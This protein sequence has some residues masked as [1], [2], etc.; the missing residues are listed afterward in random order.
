MEIILENIRQ[1]KGIKGIAIGGKELKTSAFDDYVT[2]YIGSNSSLHT[3]WNA[4]NAFR[5]SH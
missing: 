4:T 5:K 3:S 1:N 2:I